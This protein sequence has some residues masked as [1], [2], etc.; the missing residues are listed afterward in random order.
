MVRDEE[1]REKRA[2]GGIKSIEHPNTPKSKPQP[3]GYPSRV[4]SKGTHIGS[5]EGW[6]GGPPPAS[7]SASA[8]AKDS[9]DSK[10]STTL[11]DGERPTAAAPPVVG[12][13]LVRR[14]GRTHDAL[15]VHLKEMLAPERP[16]ALESLAAETRRRVMAELVFAYWQ[17]KLHHQQALYDDQR[18]GI[19]IRALKANNDNVSELLYVVDGCSRDPWPERKSHDGIEVLFRNRAQVERFA[20]FVPAYKAGQPHSTALRYG[21]GETQSA[22]D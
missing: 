21:L 18:E 6:N 15:V 11:L 5:P 4:P 22:P 17:L 20:S 14:D 12:R 16:A 10:D 9:K 2:A 13:A 1:V 19:L 3:E 7:A 8:T